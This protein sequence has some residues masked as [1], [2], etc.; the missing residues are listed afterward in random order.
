M[1]FFSLVAGLFLLA[2]FA[3]AST[4]SLNTK[5]VEEAFKGKQA[6][7]V[8]TD[9]L[10][11]ETYVSDPALG[12][13]P[14]G[15]CSTF[16]IWNTLIGLELGILKNS[17]DAFWKWDGEKRS[18]PDWNRDLTLREA[19]QASCVPAFQGLA[20]EIGPKRMQEWLDKLGYGNKDMCDRPDSF[21]LPRAGQ[22]NILI[23]PEEQAALL[24]K[25]ITGKLPVKKETVETLLNIMRIESSARSTLYGKTGSGL[26]AA[27]D[28]PSADNDFDM[29]WLVGILDCG[30]HKYSYA[31]LVLGAGLGGKDAKAA[32]QKIFR[33]SGML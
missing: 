1:R 9:T 32:V 25:L 28:G 18:F 20:R 8:V 10:T 3:R 30:G 5:A 15:P 19:F 29:G 21:W 13:E 16:K 22:P 11:G 2:G 31:C 7:I 24:N 6:V 4:M 27:K 17:D 26:R 14:F 33:D 23:T 12:R